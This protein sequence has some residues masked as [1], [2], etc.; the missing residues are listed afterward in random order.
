[1]IEI[2]ASC[3][4]API[5]WL[6]L[7][8]CGVLSIIISFTSIDSQIW[9]FIKSQICAASFHSGGNSANLV[10]LGSTPHTAAKPTTMLAQLGFDKGSVITI[11]SSA[12]C[13]ESCPMF[14]KSVRFHC[15]N[16]TGSILE[17]PKKEPFTRSVEADNSGRL[18]PHHGALMM[19]MI[20]S[21]P[22]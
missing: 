8:P 18:P 11:G 12:Y 17:T 9:R 3:C 15:R 19:P 2:I 14:Q 4:M 22:P 1:M 16:L 6:F 5:I 20:L 21:V 7:R 13:A 10:L